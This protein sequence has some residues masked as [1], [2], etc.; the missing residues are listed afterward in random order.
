VLAVLAVVLVLLALVAVVV[1]VAARG[2]SGGTSP[3]TESKRLETRTEATTVSIENECGQISLREGADGVVRTE[4]RITRLWRAPTVTSGEQGDVARVEVDCPAFSGTV[5][6]TIE[7][8]AG[9]EVEARSA[10]GGVDADGLSGRLDLRS[11]AGSVRGENLTSDDV[12]A[13]SSAGSVSLRWTDDADPQRV[14]ASSSAGSVTVLLPDRENTAYAVDADS[15]A[16]TTRVEVRTDPAA[17]RT[18]RADSSAGS[19]T[20]A[21]D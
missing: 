14:D 3:G 6:L 18:V 15:S 20:V 19:V 4:A 2:I 10:A 12:E 8:P 13:Q 11:S 9:V 17:T 21:Y 5:Q 16:G 7:V 1:L